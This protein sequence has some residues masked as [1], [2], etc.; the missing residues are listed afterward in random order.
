[1]KLIEVEVPMFKR[2]FIAL[3]LTV[4]LSMA[5]L[6]CGTDNPFD[7]GED[8]PAGSNVNTPS[9]TVSFAAEVKPAL[10]ACASCHSGGAGG[11]VYTGGVDSYTSV[12]SQID[13]QNPSNS[14]I[15]IKATGGNSHGGG[16]LFPVSNA[17]YQA[18][19]NWIAQGAKNN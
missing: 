13:L 5:L 1:L 12:S 8:L 15:L 6:G 9:A 4:G 16:A 18:I 17:K 2:T 7:R 14:L 11:W 3:S 19:L 10:Q